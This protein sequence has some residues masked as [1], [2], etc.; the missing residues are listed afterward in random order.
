M[1]DC[2]VCA[3]GKSRQ[4]AHPKTA[5]HKVTLPFQLVFADLVGP[6]T[7]EALGGYKYITKISDEYTNWTQPYL[8][9]SKH[10]ALSSFQIFVQY[11]VCLLYTSPSP[12]DRG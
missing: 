3:V 10:D 8:L 7:P 2:D 6:L 1:P 12:R 9:K 5:D 4:L 11:V